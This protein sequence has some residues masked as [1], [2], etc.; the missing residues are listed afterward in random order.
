MQ[1]ASLRLTKVE[2]SL[3]QKVASINWGLILLLAAT[4]SFGLLVP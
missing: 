2:L 4:T 1:D 3:G